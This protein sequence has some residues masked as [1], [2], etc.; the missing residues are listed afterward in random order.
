MKDLQPT[1]WR[2]CRVLAN[3]TRLD[4]LRELFEVTDCAVADLATAVN[5][6]DS[7]ASIFLREIN[8]RGL[9]SAKRAGRNVF[10]SATANP[11][12]EYSDIILNALRIAC[13]SGLGND[14][15]IHFVTAFSHPRRLQIVAALRGK[16]AAIQHLVFATGISLP[17]LHRHLRKLID[18]DMVEVADE[19][20]QLKIP[21][22]PFGQTLQKIALMQ[23]SL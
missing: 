12:V 22:C 20:C 18:R 19:H 2:T 6:S 9:I 1:L 13:A 8:A 10:Y 16:P 4:L 23:G 21:S 15:I 3:S 14:E 11:K 17:A 7:Q 5:I